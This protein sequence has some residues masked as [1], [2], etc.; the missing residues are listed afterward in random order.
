M[1]RRLLS[2]NEA[3]RELMSLHLRDDIAQVMLGIHVRLLA[4]KKAV[5]I[6]HED[7]AEKITTNR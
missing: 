1:T 7:L 3:E 2:A 6:S 5:S 4:L